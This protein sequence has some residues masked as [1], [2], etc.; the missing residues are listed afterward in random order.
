MKDV[1]DYKDIHNDFYSND[2]PIMIWRVN[3]RKALRRCCEKKLSLVAEI[4]A[5]FR[6]GHFVLWRSMC[7]QM[8]EQLV[9][10]YKSNAN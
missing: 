4:R 2:S 7:T 3:L 9:T 8:L 5:T 6:R 1:R 10:N